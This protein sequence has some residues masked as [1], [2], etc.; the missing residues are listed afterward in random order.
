MMSHPGALFGKSDTTD[1]SKL[2]DPLLSCNVS[3]D[4]GHEELVRGARFVFAM[5]EDCH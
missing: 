4:D 3:V 2:N 5:L 1:Q